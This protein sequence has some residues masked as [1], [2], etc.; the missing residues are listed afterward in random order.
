VILNIPLNSAVLSC[1]KVV[2][3]FNRCHAFKKSQCDFLGAGG[4]PVLGWGAVAVLD[5]GW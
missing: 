4:N 3:P 2:G 5:I 1:K